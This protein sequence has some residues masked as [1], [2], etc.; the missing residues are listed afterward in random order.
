M[1]VALEKVD[2]VESV[3]VTL[4]RG[5]ARLELREGN[6]VTLPQLR[7]VIRQAGYAT[8]EAAVTVRGRI[9]RRQEAL[10]LDVTGT[11]TSLKLARDPKG[12]EA[13]DALAKALSSA[14]PLDVRATGVVAEPERGASPQ[15]VLQVRSFDVVR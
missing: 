1:S 10:V 13:F 15:D 7:R 4:K 9:S 3:N 2:G 8:R 6:G 12:P 11:D 5:M 14:A